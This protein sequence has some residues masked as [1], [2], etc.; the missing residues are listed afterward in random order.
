[1]TSPAV[2]RAGVNHR[3]KFRI[4]NQGPIRVNANL[5]DYRSRLI[6]SDSQEI[7]NSG[8][9]NIQV[10]FDKL[11]LIKMIYKSIIRFLLG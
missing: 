2:L 5:F 11:V 3:V 7:N 10:S 6:S 1:M 8:Y 4:F 9:L